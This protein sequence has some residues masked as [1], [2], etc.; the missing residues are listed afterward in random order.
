MLGFEVGCVVRE[1]AAAAGLLAKLA[2]I[3]VI[4]VV[5]LAP[6][7]RCHIKYVLSYLMIL[8]I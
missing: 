3:E 5:D 1:D 2:R 7:R 4:I 8:T 6:E